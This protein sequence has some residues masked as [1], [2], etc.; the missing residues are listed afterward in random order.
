MLHGTYLHWNIFVVYLKFT[1]NWASLFNLAPS[2]WK[3]GSDKDR[4][5]WSD[6]LTVF[7]FYTDDRLGSTRKKAERVVARTIELS[8]RGS[9]GPSE[10]WSTFR[11][12]SILLQSL[13]HPVPSFRWTI[14]PLLEFLNSTFTIPRTGFPHPTAPAGLWGWSGAPIRAWALESTSSGFK[15]SVHHVVLC[16][17]ILWD[18]VS[19]HGKRWIIGILQGVWEDWQQCIISI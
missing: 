13:Y 17:V 1:F 8:W 9:G 6:T 19:T 10:L 3:P 12:L 11:T 7:L 14:P 4:E 5:L 2:A 16:H 18:S 15:F